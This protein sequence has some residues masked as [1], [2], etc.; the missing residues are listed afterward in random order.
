MLAYVR[1]QTLQQLSHSILPV[2]L[3]EAIAATEAVKR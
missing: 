2:L 3:A 1:K